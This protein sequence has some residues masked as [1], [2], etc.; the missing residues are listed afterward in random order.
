MLSSIEEAPMPALTI[1]P[2]TARDAQLAQASSLQFAQLGPGEITF[3]V[4]GKTVTLPSSAVQLLQRFLAELAQGHGIA[5]SPLE[6][7]LTTQEAADLIGVS[8]PH[9]IQRL[10]AGEVPFH[11]VGSHRRIKVEDVLAFKTKLDQVRDDAL[12]ELVEQ[13]QELSMG[14][15]KDDPVPRPLEEGSRPR[16]RRS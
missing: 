13:A 2:P 10:E 9:L 4:S 12:R 8:R 5:L 14:Y 11:M 7:Q 3:E 6:A 16:M 1:T 15:G